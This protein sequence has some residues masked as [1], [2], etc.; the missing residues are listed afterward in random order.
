L[1]FLA[2]H[3]FSRY[4]SDQRFN[5]VEQSVKRAPGRSLSALKCALMKLSFIAGPLLQELRHLGGGQ[6]V[7]RHQQIGVDLAMP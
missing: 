1:R 7:D 6:L 2:E 5:N 4:T 3:V